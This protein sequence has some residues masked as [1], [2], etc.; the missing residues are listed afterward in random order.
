MQGRGSQVPP[1]AAERD[2]G[3]WPVRACGSPCPLAVECK[4]NKRPLQLSFPAKLCPCLRPAP[5]LKRAGRQ[6]AAAVGRGAGRGAAGG[7]ARGG[8]DQG[9]PQGERRCFFYG[10]MCRLVLRAC[11]CWLEPGTNQRAPRGERRARPPCP[12]SSLP[13]IP[14][15]MPS[16]FPF[17]CALQGIEKEYEELDTVWY[18][19]GSLFNRQPFAPPTEQFPLKARRA[20]LR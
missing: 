3:V 16:G 8:A 13:D 17:P 2:R 6:V 1:A 9:A 20:A 11:L 5:L 15:P 10:R 4:R 18:L 19:A 12:F 14:R 7:V